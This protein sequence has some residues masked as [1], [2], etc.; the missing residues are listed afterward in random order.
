MPNIPIFLPPVLP[1]LVPVTGCLCRYCPPGHDRGHLPLGPDGLGQHLLG[2]L[3]PLHTQA[4]G[5]RQVRTPC[6][7]WRVSRTAGRV[8]V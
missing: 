2:S 1:S 8:V 3:A 7:T 4:L 6:S 5:D